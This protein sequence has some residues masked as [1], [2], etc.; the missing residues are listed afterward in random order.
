MFVFN[1]YSVNVLGLGLMVKIGML[2]ICLSC[3]LVIFEIVLSVVK[4]FC[5]EM[6]SWDRLLL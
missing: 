1:L 5:V 4:I 2:L 3:V 6:I